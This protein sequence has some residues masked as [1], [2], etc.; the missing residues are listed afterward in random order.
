MSAD[1]YFDR[2]ADKDT[3]PTAAVTS[4][5]TAATTSTT[6]ATSTSTTSAPTAASTSTAP[7]PPTGKEYLVDPSEAVFTGTKKYPSL[8]AFWQLMGWFNAGT[9]QKIEAPDLFGCVELPTPAMCF[10]QAEPYT[11]KQREALVGQLR[12]DKAQTM[13]WPPSLKNCFTQKP[14]SP[15]TTTTSTASAYFASSN[16]ASATATAT[17]PSATALKAEKPLYGSPMLEEALGQ[18]GAVKQVLSVLLEG[19]EAKKKGK[20]V[21]GREN[22]AQF[23]SNLPPEIPT[24]WAQCEACKKWR[25]VAWFVDSKALPD[26]WHCTMNT[27]DADNATCAAPQ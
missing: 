17:A 16:P 14:K 22:A 8:F 21:S 1:L 4:T 3:A 15:P 9:D 19:V 2:A 10:G 5:S 23:D 11:A 7:A 26:E 13:S 18:V 6:T 20:G 27:W 25:R 12:D 24:D